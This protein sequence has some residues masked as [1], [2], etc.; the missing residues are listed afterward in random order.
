MSDVDSTDTIDFTNLDIYQAIDL[1]KAGC[2]DVEHYPREYISLVKTIY[3][4]RS[5]TF[6]LDYKY[7]IETSKLEAFYDCP[8]CYQGELDY[9]LEC[10]L[11]KGTGKQ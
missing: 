1:V 11:C 8:K 6:Q 5:N 10:D 3:P 2:E 4:T 9:G 7:R